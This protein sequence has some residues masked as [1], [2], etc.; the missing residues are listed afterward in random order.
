MTP[1]L[2]E[3]LRVMLPQLQSMSRDA[4]HLCFAV[5]SHT[6]KHR[7]RPTVTGLA[8]RSI[9]GKFNIPSTHLAGSVP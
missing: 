6:K 2:F 7:I 4:M 9:M 3:V 8:M 1:K 5:D